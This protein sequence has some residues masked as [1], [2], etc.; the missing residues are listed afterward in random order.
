MKV[1]YYPGCSLHGTG[2]EYAE[3][4]ETVCRKLGAELV[5]HEDWNCCGA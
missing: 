3:S 1:S 4:T 2:K 5:E